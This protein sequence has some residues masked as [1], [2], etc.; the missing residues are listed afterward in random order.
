MDAWISI[1]FDNMTSSYFQNNQCSTCPL[2]GQWKLYPLQ[3][4]S[5]VLFTKSHHLKTLAVIADLPFKQK[6]RSAVLLNSCSSTFKNSP[7]RYLFISGCSRNTEMTHQKKGY[8]K[9]DHKFL[10]EEL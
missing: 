6:G 9:S 4:G 8:F 3:T 2:F 5:C 10:H 1:L 7:Y